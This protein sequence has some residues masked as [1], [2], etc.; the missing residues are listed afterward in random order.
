MGP[1]HDQ[2]PLLLNLSHQHTKFVKFSFITKE[3]PLSLDCPL[4]QNCSTPLLP[5]VIKLLKEHVCKHR[6]SPLLSV[7]LHLPHLGSD[8]HHSTGTTLS[9]LDSDWVPRSTFNLEPHLTG[10][11]AACDPSGHYPILETDT[12]LACRRHAPGFPPTSL[13]VPSQP[14]LRIFLT[15]LTSNSGLLLYLFSPPRRHG[16]HTCQPCCVSGLQFQ[17]LPEQL[18]GNLNSMSHRHLKL[19]MPKAEGMLP[20]QHFLLPGLLHVQG[21]V[22]TPF[23]LVTQNRNGVIPDSTFLLHIHSNMHAEHDYSSH[24]TTSPVQATTLSGLHCYNSFKGFPTSL[25]HQPTN[26]RRDCLSVH[27]A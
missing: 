27:P 10:P 26:S 17:S 3:N 14:P 25:P 1:L 21:N 18:P 2:C 7:C 12:S 15:F 19:S 24:P 11:L 8:P 20:P 5:F 9:K 13:A 4:F 16:P 6:P 23:F 22:A